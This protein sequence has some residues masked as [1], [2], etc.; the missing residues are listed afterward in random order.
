MNALDIT[1]DD[2]ETPAR[3]LEFMN[4]MDITLDDD[5]THAS[6]GE[7]SA[8]FWN[9]DGTFGTAGWAAEERAP[10]ISDRS[11]ATTKD[12]ESAVSDDSQLFSHSFV[13]SINFGTEA[14]SDLGNPSQISIQESIDSPQRGTRTALITDCPP[15]ETGEHNSVRFGVPIS[16]QGD[17]GNNVTESTPTVLYRGE[18]ED[19]HG[20]HPRQP[21]CGKEA[22][23]PHRNTK[24]TKNVL[25]CFSPEDETQDLMTELSRLDNP[26]EW[27]ERDPEVQLTAAMSPSPDPIDPQ[28]SEEMNAL[29]NWHFSNV[30]PTHNTKKIDAQDPFS[31][32]DRFAASNI[33][34][35]S[36]YYSKTFN[37]FVEETFEQ[38]DSFDFQLERTAGFFSPYGD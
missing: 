34:A 27:T 37:P 1:V 22:G 29:K 15:K 14:T 31:K 24:G 11:K 25:Q 35:G 16:F 13:S 23:S 2:D 9:P 32:G 12:D 26:E 7:L 8:I 3:I 17:S 6:D 19:E 5:T 33:A 4:E 18:W 36:Q 38:N 21:P 10:S 30:P 28:A 20:V